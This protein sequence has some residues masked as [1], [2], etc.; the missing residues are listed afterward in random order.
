LAPGQVALFGYGSLFSTEPGATLGRR[1]G[2]YVTRAA[3]MAAA[4]DTLRTASSI[5]TESADVSAVDSYLNVHRTRGRCNGAFFGGS[6]G[7]GGLRTSGGIYDR[8]D[9]VNELERYVE[10]GPG[11]MSQAGTG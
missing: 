10:S 2:P 7:T 5:E 3:R 4:W 11:R 8:V 9:I 6:T 1:C